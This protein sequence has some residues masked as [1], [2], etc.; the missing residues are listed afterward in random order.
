MDT[1]EI[2]ATQNND[3][4]LDT[5]QKVM[6]GIVAFVVLVGGYFV[7]R[8]E[9][10]EVAKQSIEE[11]TSDLASA[12]MV[13]DGEYTYSLGGLE[14]VFEPQVEDETGA[15]ATRVR[16]KLKDFKRDNVPI[17][18]ALYRLGTYRG[19]CQSF[20]QMPE[21]FVLP[22]KDS[23]AFTQCWFAGAGRQLMVFQ[24]GTMLEVKVRILA[25]EDVQPAPLS[26]ILSIDLTKIVQSEL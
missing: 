1:Q 25:E 4:G 10:K 6:I 5:G 9:Q 20:E 12:A 7:F 11:E 19:T 15:P 16:L 17:D 24:K 14:W 13:I 2:L 21:G 23:L 3:E 18:V 22:E 26:K 8:P